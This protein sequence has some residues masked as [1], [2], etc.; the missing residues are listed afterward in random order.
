MVALLPFRQFMVAGHTLE[1]I[2]RI[3]RHRLDPS[4]AIGPTSDGYFI[5]VQFWQDH[6]C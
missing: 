3:A 2:R 6:L 1:C 5:L 4:G